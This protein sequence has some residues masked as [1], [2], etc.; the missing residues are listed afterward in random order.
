MNMKHANQA[1]TRNDKQVSRTT[2][3]VNEN[4]YSTIVCKPNDERPGIFS[5]EVV[6]P[7][8]FQCSCKLVEF[9][10]PYEHICKAD[11]EILSRVLGMMLT[12]EEKIPL[13]RLS[14]NVEQ[15]GKNVSSNGKNN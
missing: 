3:F 8:N 7:P 5:R 1:G 13:K 12:K 15:H 10:C 11:R 14:P 2:T 6:V 9:D 4:M